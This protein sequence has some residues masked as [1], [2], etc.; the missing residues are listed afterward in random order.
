MKKINFKEFKMYVD[1]RKTHMVRQD[2]RERMADLL[3]T[4][5]NGA[6]AASL[7]MKIINSEGDIEITDFE[8]KA[9][10]NVVNSSC[11]QNI[12]DGVFEALKNTED[13]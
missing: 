9:L 7:S 12:I 4:T 5:A 2:I 3:Y 6:A 13:S 8:K 10:I 1:F 11:S